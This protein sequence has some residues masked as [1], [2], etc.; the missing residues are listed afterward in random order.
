[1]KRP[2]KPNTALAMERVREALMHIQNAQDELNRACSQL[3]CLR[4]GQPQ[5]R[6]T[7]K[8]AD[9][10]HAYWYVLR[11]FGDNNNSLSDDAEPES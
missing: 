2:K 7:A 8:L 9:R 5:W 4:F 11:E 6:K 10:V 1:M 3:S